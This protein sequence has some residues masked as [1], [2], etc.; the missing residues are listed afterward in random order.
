MVIQIYN[1]KYVLKNKIDEWQVK[2]LKFFL[3]I[4]RLVENKKG[5][6]F[7]SPFL[8]QIYHKLNLLMLW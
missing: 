1:R 4:F 7:F 3:L 5:E 8:P 6:N 2:S